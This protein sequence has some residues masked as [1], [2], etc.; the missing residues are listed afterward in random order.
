MILIYV[1][2]LSV[3]SP[4]SRFK[5]F[6]TF[7]LQVFIYPSKLLVK[8]SITTALTVSMSFFKWRQE[9]LAVACN[10]KLTHTA[11]GRSVIL[12]YTHQIVAF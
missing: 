6:D 1:C 7:N 9:R 8:G 2:S 3:Y 5:Q 12:L 4:T 11:G 10:Y